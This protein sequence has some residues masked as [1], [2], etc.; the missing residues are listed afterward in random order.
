MSSDSNHIHLTESQILQLERQGCY[1]P[2]WHKVM[3]TAA[4]DLALIR[5]SR[6]YGDVR[7]GS[8]V[9]DSENLQG[10][11]G[12]VV[13]DC[14]IGDA[15]YVSNVAGE[16]RGIEIDDHVV[17]ENVGRITAD[18]ESPCGLGEQVSVLDETGSRPV[19]LFPD[20]TAQLASLMAHYPR[21]AENII[22]PMLKEEWEQAPMGGYIGRGVVIR[23]V[24]LI[25]NVRI[26]KDIVVEGASRLVNGR[27]INNA[28]ASRRLSYIGSD[29][30]A[31][32]FMVVDGRVDSGALLRNCFVGQGAEIGK[33]FTAHDSLF[34][35]NCSCECGEA[36]TALA[37]PYTVTMHKSSLLIGAEY[38]FMNAGSGTN[39][40]NHMYKLGP[41]HWGIM[42]RGVKTSSGAY[43]MW[44]GKIGAFSLLMGQH[45]SHPDTSL[46]P[47]SYLFATDRG[48]TI[49]T[50]GI[51]LRSCGLMRDKLKWPK[52]DR[53]KD[54]DVPL[55]DHITFDVLNPITVGAMLKALPI[56]DEMSASRPEPDGFFHYNGLLLTPGGIKR[57][58]EFYVMAI[59]K[60]FHTVLASA[61][62]ET[63]ILS[64]LHVPEEW[65]EIGTQIAP[66]SI[67]NE[68]RECEDSASITQVLDN[69]FL[70]Y[71]ALEYSWVRKLVTPSWAD[72]LKNAQ[73][74]ID[75]L[76]REIEADRASALASIRK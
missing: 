20:L 52:R 50:P 30:D 15:A 23:D 74:F 59:V 19:P 21:L 3:V 53:R 54:S 63:E 14:K 17:I 41:V 68:I 28:T 8:L 10:I 4:T 39:A 69:A 49:V 44:D 56:L 25:H 73:A 61:P 55:M 43:I 64:R 76:D 24:K 62:E 71:K 27:I 60:Y 32:N 47:F 18:L 42:Q 33:H 38:S 65:I 40:S 5:M 34:F 13:H 9:S 58:R 46:F 37:G 48:S 31:E 51:M 7:I 2:T 35:A 70:H 67:I 6:F 11:F 72:L 1:S 26:D 75:R 57:G 36:C 66:S 22:L 12:A 45:K 16:L 29:V